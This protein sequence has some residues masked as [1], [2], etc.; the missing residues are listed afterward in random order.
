MDKK[1]AFISRK[2]L[3]A[4]TGITLLILLSG[5]QQANGNIQDITGQTPGFFNHY[6]VYPFSVLLK[7]FADWFQGSYGFSIILVTLMIRFVLL[8][9]AL[10]QSKDQMQMKGKMAY[11]QPELKA[12]QEKMK[13]AKDAETKTKLQQETM[14]IYQKHNI[15]PLAA[16]GGCLPLLIQLPFLTGFYYAIQR[17]PEIAE[18]SFLWFNLGSPDFTLT[19]LAAGIYYIQSRVSLIGLEETQKKQMAMFSYLSPIMIGV[20]SLTAPSALPLYW[21]IGG[22]FVIL[23]TLLTKKLFQAEPAPLS[24]AKS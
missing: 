19:L 3:L 2:T 24:M 17:T 12:L 8:P 1:A 15:N 21:T 20:F 16:L 10:K 18:H 23:Q 14:K 5:C 7:T 13:T 9:F 6:F 4:L 22:I 11:A